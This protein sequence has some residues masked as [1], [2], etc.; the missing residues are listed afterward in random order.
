MAVQNVIKRLKNHCSKKEVN[1]ETKKVIKSLT[2]IR[3]E[4][5]WPI[6]NDVSSV[7]NNILNQEAR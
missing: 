6:A 1:T 5:L 2:G 7:N 3:Y 4:K